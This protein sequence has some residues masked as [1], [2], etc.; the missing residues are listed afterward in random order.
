[1]S[2]NKAVIADSEAMR[3]SL[4]RVKRYWVAEDEQFDVISYL[5]QR[6]P[7]EGFDIGDVVTVETVRGNRYYI[8]RLE[9]ASNLLEQ[10]TS[11][12]DFHARF[13]QRLP[14]S[15]CYAYPRYTDGEY[16]WAVKPTDDSQ[17][18]SSVRDAVESAGFRMD[19]SG[20]LLDSNGECIPVAYSEGS[21]QGAKDKRADQ[22]QSPIAEESE[23]E[24][25]QL[26]DQEG[27][28]YVDRFNAA[29]MKRIEEL[30]IDRVREGWDFFNV[31]GFVKVQKLDELDLIPNDDLAIRAARAAGLY[32]DMYGNVLRSDGL[33]LQDHPLDRKPSGGKDVDYGLVKS[34]HIDDGQLDDIEPR[35]CFLL[36]YE[37]ALVDAELKTG[38]AFARPIHSANVDRVKDSCKDREYTLN[39]MHEDG[40]EDWY[41]LQVRPRA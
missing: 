36:G 3:V 9:D 37:L 17:W 27:D 41:W 23:P 21:L 4:E 19:V 39:A 15:L 30:A 10:A 38:E 11:I 12:A 16:N 18:L 26:S 32:V 7:L 8:R 20:R 40:S 6:R 13:H 35:V 2:L 24:A 29:E 14:S 22:D 28:L 1:M 34:F 25:P 33:K 5:L 31:D